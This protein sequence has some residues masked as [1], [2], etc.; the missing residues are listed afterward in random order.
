MAGVQPDLVF[1][2]AVATAIIV[3]IE[4]ALVW[5]LLGGLLLVLLLGPQRP[6]GATVL[7]LLVVT[8]LAFFAARAMGPT[9]RLVAVVAA[10]VLT[11]GYHALLLAILAVTQD[12]PLGAFAVRGVLVAAV[13]NAVVA[14]FAAFVLRALDARFGA[15]ERTW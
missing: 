2:L 15:P 8:G 7:A 9:R 4:D 14:A 10:F 12:V 3:G 5:A 13:L 6:V 11:W 1:A